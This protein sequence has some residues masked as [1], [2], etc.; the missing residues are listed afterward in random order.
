MPSSIRAGPDAIYLLTAYAKA[1]REDLTPADTKALTRLVAAIKEGAS[2]KVTME[3]TDLGCEI[4]TALGEVLAHV[5]GET[6]LSCRIVDDPAVSRIVALRKRLQLSRQKFADPADR[7]SAP[8]RG[9]SWRSS[10]FAGGG[11]SG[12]SDE[13]GARATV[14]RLLMNGAPDDGGV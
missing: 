5:R 7:S 2:G 6:D 12:T 11:S 10:R 14:H 1:D 3:R 9:W 8:D 13:R 4:E